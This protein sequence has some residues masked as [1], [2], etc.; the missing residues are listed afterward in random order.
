M[1]RATG[2]HV[3]KLALEPP[4]ADHCDRK[5]GPEGPIPGLGRGAKGL[6]PRANLY[7]SGK[8][9]L[10]KLGPFIQKTRKDTS[11]DM[12]VLGDFLAPRP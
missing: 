7:F 11:P 12:T 8:R 9:W 5:R 3:S 4:K 2:T 6:K 1:K 10:T